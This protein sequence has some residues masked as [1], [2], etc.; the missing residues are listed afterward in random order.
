LAKIIALLALLW[1][2]PAWA[3][4]GIVIVLN[5]PLY[6]GPASDE[7][8]VDYVRQGQKIFILDDDLDPLT[9]PTSSAA[10]PEPDDRTIDVY[11]DEQAGEDPLNIEK[12]ETVYTPADF[13]RTVDKLGEIV[14][15]PKPY[16]KIIFN[17]D[18]EQGQPIT[19]PFDE[20]DYR[21]QDILPTDFPF[22]HKAQ[23][24]FTVSYQL[25]PLLAQHYDY[26][27][28][29]A[30]RQDTGGHRQGVQIDWA[31]TLPQ[32]QG[33][34]R[35]FGWRI[36]YWGQQQNLNFAQQ[37]NA[38]ESLSTLGFGPFFAYQPWRR[39]YFN[40]EFQMGGHLHLA[41][42]FIHQ[43][44]TSTYDEMAFWGLLFSTSLKMQLT[45][46]DLVPWVD[47][48]LAVE[49]EYFFPAHLRSFNDSVQTN[50]WQKS[51]RRHR[52]A[53]HGQGSLLLGL[54]H[55]F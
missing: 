43:E 31:K 25:G 5:A 10:T 13:Y 51:P 14:Y 39:S 4:R 38:Q 12:G 20:T 55:T 29:V 18:R 1:G 3:A 50:W 32:E 17:D 35:Y 24:Q 26:P 11:V 54:G 41:R 40:L 53:A 9:L 15:I 49:G 28:P 48:V 33:H 27:W 52:L 23:H 44:Q 7:K 34:R 21:L 8:I 16:V 36:T 2:L 47:L 46:I 6:Q 45:I 42:S 30:D 22:H 37:Q 19:L